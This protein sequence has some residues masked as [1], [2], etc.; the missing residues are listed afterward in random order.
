MVV[1]VVEIPASTSIRTLNTIAAHIKHFS[2]EREVLM[3]TSDPGPDPSSLQV[4]VAPT[5]NP[6]MVLIF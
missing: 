5:S 3:K 6:L 2:G 1:E 4:E